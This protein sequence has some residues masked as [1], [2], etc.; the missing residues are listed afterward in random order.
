MKYIFTFLFFI[1][2]L[3]ACG[4]ES[5]SDSSESSVDSQESGLSEEASE[6]KICYIA[7]LTGMNLREEPSTRGVVLKLLPYN[8]A[9][10]VIGQSGKMETI[11]GLMGEWIEV[12]AE[13]QKGFIFSGYTIPIPLPGRNPSTDLKGYFAEHL[14][15]TIN[16][17]C[18]W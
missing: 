5:I 11:D 16:T 8:T 6:S 12:K 15:R 17:I 9:C 2:V 13:D 14:I 4:G 18:N 10:E 1:Y 3:L 7:A